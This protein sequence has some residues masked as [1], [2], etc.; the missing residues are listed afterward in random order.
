MPTIGKG[1]KKIWVRV[2]TEAAHHI[3]EYFGPYDDLESCFSAV[4]RL[5]ETAVSHTRDD[6][7]ERHIGIEILTE[8][9]KEDE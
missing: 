6:R 2:F 4:Q 7:I 5:T 1:K 8:K 9:P 3:R